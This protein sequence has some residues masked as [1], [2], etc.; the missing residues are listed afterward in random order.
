MK[1]YKKFFAALLAVMHVLTFSAP[2]Q[3]INI[4]EGT[5][6]VVDSIQVNEG[7]QL[8]INVVDQLGQVCPSCRGILETNNFLN[9]GAIDIWGILAI[10]APTI[11]NNGSITVQGD[12]LLSNLGI[13]QEQFFAG[14][15]ELSKDPSLASG[16]ILNTGDITNL[17]QGLL[18]LVAANGGV[19]NLGTI[20]S[21]GGAI[22]L[23]AGDRASFPLTRDG[24]LNIDLDGITGVKGQVFDKDGN[25]I[26]TNG[27][28]TNAGVLQANGGAVVLQAAG[29]EAIYDSIINHTGIIEAKSVSQENG[30]II[31]K[32]EAGNITV[33]N[34]VIDASGYDAGEKGGSIELL[35]HGNVIAEGSSTIDASGDIGG[36]TI[37][38]GSDVNVTGPITAEN[39]FV[40]SDVEVKAD[41]VTNGDGGK[42]IVGA[43]EVALAYGNFSAKGGAQSGNG[44]FIETSG[45][46][47]LDIDG[48]GIDASASNG[49]AGTWL[50]DPVNVNVVSSTSGNTQVNNISNDGFTTTFTSSITGANHRTDVL[51]STIVGLLEA[52]TN[53]KL[54]TGSGAGD[55]NISILADILVSSVPALVATLTLEAAGSITV[56]A[57]IGASAGFLLNVI[58]T[59]VQDIN[60]NNEVRTNGGD[61]TVTAGDRLN[62]SGVVATSGGDISFTAN[63]EDS[64]IGIEIVTEG[65][66]AGTGSVSL[67]ATS[68]DVKLSSSIVTDGS[69]TIAVSSSRDIVLDNSSSDITSGGGDITFTADSDANGTGVFNQSNSGSVITTFNAA[70]SGDVTINASDITVNGI[71]NADDGTVFLKNSTVGRTFGLG[72]AAGDISISSFEA[73]R[74][75]ADTLEIGT[76]TAGN[77]QADGFVSDPTYLV[78]RTGNDVLGTG[79]GTDVDAGNVAIH[80]GGAVNLDT[81]VGTIAVDAVGPVVLNELSSLV[82]GTV[83]GLSGITTVDNNIEITTSL[84]GGSL[85]LEQSLNAGTGDITLNIGYEIN[86]TGGTI[87]A[88]SLS[89][90]AEE[91]VSLA[92]AGNTWNTITGVTTTGAINIADSGTNTTVQNLQTVENTVTYNHTGAGDVT[93]TG[94]V[95]SGNGSTNG[96]NITINSSNALTLDV[97]GVISS[98]AGSGGTVSLGSAVI[99]GAITAGDGDIT[100][101]GGALVLD[102]IINSPLID[103]INI[104]ITALRDVIISSSVTTTDGASVTVTADTDLD[105]DG[106]V[107][108]KTGAD[109]NSDANLTITGSK[110]NDAG[111]NGESVRID[112]GATVDAVGDI[113]IQKSSVAPSTAD[114]VVNGV[115][116]TTGT[117]TTITVDS[118]RDLTTTVD[119]TANLVGDNIDLTA[120]NDIDV[121]IDADSLFLETTTGDI[122]AEDVL[123]GFSLEGFNNP[124]SGTLTLTTH[125]PM[126]IA[127]DIIQAAVINLTALESGDVDDHLIVDDNVTV[128]S[129]AG[130]V[131]L[132]AGDN[133]NVNTGALVKSDIGAVTITAGSVD[134]DDIGS[135]N[136]AGDVQ[137]D[138]ALTLNALTTSGLVGLISQTA[139]ALTAVDLV[140]NAD[141]SATLNQAANNVTTLAATTGGDVTYQ[142]ATDL[143]LKASTIGGNLSVTTA[144][145]LTDSGDLSVTGTTILDAGTD[146]V[147]LNNNN[148]FGGAV[149][150]IN[151]D[152]VTLNDTGDL[153][154]DNIN[155]TT[156]IVLNAG[157][158]ITDANAALNNVT[159]SSL[160]ATAATGIDLDTTI[161]TLTNANVTGIGAIDIDNMGALDVTSATTTD[162]A[163][164]INATGGDLNTTIVTAGGAARNVNLST[165]TSGNIGLGVI[166]ALD[167]TVTVTSAGEIQELVNDDAGVPTAEV[168]AGTIQLN[169]NGDIGAS[170]S[171]LDIQPSVKWGAS[172][173]GNNLFI[174]CIGDCPIDQVD[175]GTSTFH[176]STSGALTD[177][178]DPVPATGEFAT[179][180]AGVWNIA[181]GGINIKTGA[182]FGTDTNAIELRLSDF[183]GTANTDGRMSVD[184]GTG[185]VYATN[186]AQ[187]GAGLTIGGITGSF[188]DG[189]TA[190]DGIAIY[191]GSPLTVAADAAETMGGNILLAAL[192]TALTDN[193][194]LNSGVTVSTTGGTG[195]VTLAGGN[196]VVLNSGSTVSA[197]SSGTVRV[198]SG[199]DFTDATFDQ[200]GNAGGSVNMNAAAAVTSSNGIV[201]LDARN[202]IIAG[203]VNAVTANLTARSGSITDANGAISNVNAISLVASGVTGIDLDTTVTNITATN[204]GAGN[205]IINE[206]NGAQVLNV[207]AAD[208]NATVT[209]D[210][211]NLNVT[212]ANASGSVTLTATGGS[213]TD[214]NAAAS[215]VTA[216]SLTASAGTGIDLDTTITTLTNANVTGTGAININDLAGGL[217]VTSATTNNG[218]I[219]INAAGGNLDATTVTA[220]GTSRNVTLSTTTSGN[221]NVGNVTAAGDNIVINSAG[222]IEELGS[223]NA[224]DLRS[225]TMDLQSVS[226]IG[227]LGTL[228]IN[229]TTLTNASVSAAGSIDLLDVNNGLTVTNAT[230]FDGDISITADSGDLNLVSV[231][232]GAPGA[233]DG[234]VTLTT[235]T[236]G[237]VN[238]GDVQARG[239]N[240]TVVSAGLIEELGLDNAADLRSNTM[241]LQ[242]VSGI[243]T[244]GTLEINA[245]TLT[246]ASA[247]AAGSINLLDVNNGLVVTNATTFD[248]GINITADNGDLTAMNVVAGGT[249]DVD[250]TTTTSGDIFLETVSA[251]DNVATITSAGTIQEFTNDDAGVQHS[252]VN[253]GTINLTTGGGDIGAFVSFLDITPTNLWNAASNGGDIYISC[254]GVCP[255]GQIDAGTGF[256]YYTGNIIDGNDLVNGEIAGGIWNIRAGGVHL[257]ADVDTTNPA[258]GINEGGIG[259]VD[260]WIEM[261]L[262]RDV[263]SDTVLDADGIFVAKAATGG[264]HV[265]NDVPS[266]ATLGLQIG[267]VGAFPLAV[268]MNDGVTSAGD[269]EIYS[270]SPLVI[271]AN[272]AATNGANIGL[273]SMGNTN[274]DDLTVNTGITVSSTGDDGLGVNG[275][276]L[277]TA[278]SRLLLEDNAVVITA[279]T[280]TILAF[281]GEDFT[282][283]I[284]DLDGANNSGTIRMDSGSAFRS[285]DGNIA[286]IAK[287]NARITEVNADSNGTGVQ[288]DINVTAVNGY[289]SDRNGATVNL[290]GDHAVLTANLGVGDGAVADNNELETSLNTVD[291]VNGTSG[292]IN[293]VETAAGGDLGIILAGQVTSNG[294]LN[295][296]TTDGNL[297]VIDTAS[298][299]SGVHANDGET[300]LIANGAGKDLIVNNVVDSTTGKINLDSTG[301]DV[302]FSADGDVTATGG[303]EIEVDA[304]N[305]IFMADG[306]VLEANGG[307]IE[308]G[309][310]L[311]AGNDITL[312]SV[313]TTSA[314]AVDVNNDGF[315]A[316]DI[317]AGGAVIDGGDSSHDIIANI[318]QTTINAVNGIG[319]GDS[320]E[321]RLDSLRATNTT[322]NDI[323]VREMASGGDLNVVGIDQQ[324]LTGDVNIRTLNG[325]L[326]VMAAATLLSGFAGGVAAVDGVTRLFARDNDNS[327][328]DHLIIN[329][330]V[331]SADG[332]INLD[333]ENDVIASAE[334]DVTAGD[335]TRKLGATG[336]EIEVDAVDNITM[337]DG[338]IFNANAG[339]PNGGIDMDAVNG[340]ITLGSVQTSNASDN[341]VTIHT[342]NGAIIDG[343]DI[344]RDIVN[345]GNGGVILSAQTGIGS[346]GTGLNL[347]PNSLT[348][349]F[350]PDAIDMT[351]AGTRL[352]AFTESGDIQVQNIGALEITTLSD[353][354]GGTP[355]GSAGAGT[356]TGVQIND[357]LVLDPNS[358]IFITAASP[359]TI[360]SQVTNFD[361]GNISLYALG[362]TP[363]DTM[364]INA[365]VQ[366]LN[367]NGDVRI[368]SGG[369][370]TLGAGVNVSTQGDGVTSGAGR[371]AMGAG[372]DAT[373]KA[374]DAS[375]DVNPL[376]AADVLPGL[377][378]VSLASTSTDPAGSLFDTA[379]SV[380]TV[381]NLT[382]DETSRISTES[383]RIII[384]A[385]NNFTVG[386]VDADGN[387]GANGI[388]DGVVGNILAFARNGSILDAEGPGEVGNLDF[389]ANSLTMLAA[390]TIGLSNNRI[391]GVA[392]FLNTFSIG[393]QFISILGDTQVEM[394]SSSGS[395]SLI[396]T[397]NI[398]LGHM[399]APSGV[400]QA[401]AGGSIFSQGGGETRVTAFNLIELIANGIIGTTSN[402]I[403]THLN[404]TPAQMNLSAGGQAPNGVSIAVFGNVSPAAINF[405]TNPPGLALFNGAP[406]AGQS[407]SGLIGNQS[408]LYYKAFVRNLTQYSDFD[409]N[410]AADFPGF[411]NYNTMAV[412][413]DLTVDTT[414]L[415]IPLRGITTAPRVVPIPRP[416]VPTPVQPA[417]SE[418]VPELEAQEPTPP[419]VVPIPANAVAS[420]QPQTDEG[421]P[422][423][424]AVSN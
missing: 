392:P 14:I 211:G 419:V 197:A 85:N 325:S 385:Q 155:A 340:N 322:A 174:N 308:G 335:V 125:S 177:G 291:V 313:R 78:L 138:T 114:I 75:W 394:N 110:I 240:I 413:P 115:V 165:T 337:A 209:S 369:D 79:V 418:Q 175:L 97:G 133:V 132:S 159:S 318:G 149:S 374:A 82:V 416:A 179:P 242:S 256:F 275:N 37:L 152:N 420:D 415:D 164:T 203:V 311:D 214:A 407:L 278:G 3:Q 301:N 143:D 178:N 21:N 376:F 378:A 253:A 305:D 136:L 347:V 299:G 104:V 269:V 202:S 246:N 163:V 257:N 315:N 377:N 268:G 261:R 140:V 332:K 90:T 250:L 9:N 153:S 192:G 389:V 26:D 279:G 345:T 287:E 366:S 45:K 213:I 169:S 158:A 195:N 10:I 50:L 297:T 68:G 356:V 388:T 64:N 67:N 365:N 396:A 80:A 329:N 243:G 224:A 350:A 51:A 384:D 93:V 219:T 173:N 245:T 122:S 128:Q 237:N 357:P 127:V 150:V 363:A 342:E 343:G 22:V 251:L 405:L 344:H 397:G 289:I 47:Y 74:V 87:I 108:L 92:Q 130:D 230:T 116:T 225:N 105:G 284:L 43:R 113:T 44:G 145:D 1:S 339:G 281:A 324:A 292:E 181:A 303:A 360:S 321:V 30:K 25:L 46:E 406:V 109:I 56:S 412:S 196:N 121:E 247:S 371:V 168:V 148:N 59:A 2:A 353:N 137:A 186:A 306:T 293:I 107:W 185:G 361:G 156:A 382:M 272:V 266:D 189:I 73:S 317:N 417:E 120:V 57:A 286:L 386:R 288:G 285:E 276:I 314:L 316:V 11:I 200:D 8:S 65:L 63:G 100:L 383:G 194:T 91:F 94:T 98:L 134:T 49:V 312:G 411:M 358:I 244:L 408:S 20:S 398:L 172:T 222:A 422:E 141:D 131:N 220:G 160:D 241:D 124:G 62:S 27:L 205:I 86:Q 61:L 226:G 309:I 263:N 267:S 144:G 102:T 151:A 236:S 48:I 81:N 15:A 234:N 176:F 72:S 338:T 359:M 204:S 283:S 403:H 391:E 139:G 249:G 265:S 258:D 414:G 393:S 295:I 180:D 157:G 328:A 218:A 409:G 38:I 346:R 208:G 188:V 5:T 119:G 206:V 352:S 290:I 402:P 147:V 34:A 162:G 24:I 310:D 364:T 39:V 71:I 399:S 42:I 227:T 367:G 380:N 23:A 7:E 117:G 103:S 99:N 52:G 307:G 184:G 95:S 118:A 341:A 187:T 70:G 215:N 166:T 400:V 129:T 210:T 336:A 170:T 216:T 76:A 401:I 319:H 273:H 36:G 355:M 18:A 235:T 201:F 248:G 146:D 83:K 212:T 191:S 161:T 190:Q 199:E 331:R 379:N 296:R 84:G 54:V 282:D 300:R 334:G 252:D 330:T 167:D 126:T 370:M 351:G 229:A 238:V 112:A 348:D 29:A 60:I 32:S 77:I 89:F 40:G 333:S 410:Y 387:A 260:N 372:F 123:G 327:G 262:A 221:V 106:G 69:G 231:V 326:T 223:D 19:H 294:D 381:A 302:R 362:G 271:A 423:T 233:G 368:V 13:N 183:G 239:D 88:D 323:R 6:L 55:G 53:V 349:N 232:A 154:V 259:A 270:F 66:S 304:A 58:M 198:V 4:Q 31:L 33:N 17:T 274:V 28:V 424:P 12:L 193:L 320:L 373:G 395:L 421:V 135:V 298:F 16:Y 217:A 41:A 111:A 142:D 264:V 404:A 254:I 96:G 171:Y 228:E 354:N 35:T 375:I 390:G 182:G 101:S 277:M 255:M 207:N 280:G